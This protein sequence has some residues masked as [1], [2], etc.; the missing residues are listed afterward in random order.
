MD[1]KLYPV[2]LV[3]LH[4]HGMCL[5]VPPFVMELGLMSWLLL[6][7]RYLLLQNIK[8]VLYQDLRGF[9]TTISK[10]QGEV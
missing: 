3:V 6:T 1:G 2:P 8:G 5:L 10:A 9:R 7:G 4:A